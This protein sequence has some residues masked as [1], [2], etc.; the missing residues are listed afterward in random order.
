MAVIRATQ[1]EA[2]YKVLYRG[3][4]LEEFE[5]QSGVGLGYI[6]PPILQPLMNSCLRRVV[7]T[8]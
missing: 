2:K 3:K 8:L 7:W 6:F 5:V 1:D 4:I